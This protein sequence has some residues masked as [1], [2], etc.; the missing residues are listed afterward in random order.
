M[1]FRIFQFNRAKKIQIYFKLN[2]SSSKLEL[3]LKSQ[4]LE[5]T[6]G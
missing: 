4:C 1:D 6:V 2:L 3:N 5:E